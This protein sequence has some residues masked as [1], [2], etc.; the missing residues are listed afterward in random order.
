MRKYA[1]FVII[2]AG[3]ILGFLTGIY[4]YRIDQV[5]MKKLAKVNQEEINNILSTDNEEI[6]NTIKTNTEEEK[7][8][9]NCNL[10]LKVYYTKCDHL[11][12]NR[13]LIE[14]T[15]VNMT[16]EELRDRFKE[17]E[18]QKFTPTEIILYKEINEFCNEHYLLK[19]KDGYIAIYKLDENNNSQIFQTTE[20]STEYLAEEDLEDINQGI[21]VYTKK[22]LN[23]ILEDFE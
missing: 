4:L 16:E 18:I 1:I 9:P 10:I 6:L 22:E 23:K 13:E 3:I 5:E 21:A 12:E 20:I 7:V 15:A 14:D 2:I 8:S 11:I 17:W 19:D